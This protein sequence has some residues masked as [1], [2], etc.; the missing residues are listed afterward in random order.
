MIPS[1]QPNLPPTHSVSPDPQTPPETPGKTHLWLALLAFPTTSVLLFAIMWYVN[2]TTS[3]SYGSSLGC[4]WGTGIIFIMIAPIMFGIMVV[5]LGQSRIRSTNIGAVITIAAL[6]IIANIWFLDAVF[7]KAQQ[8]SYGYLLY[9]T[10]FGIPSLVA[11][12][13]VLIR[14]KTW[15]YAYIA[16]YAGLLIIG[17][18]AW[19]IVLLPQ[20][21]SASIQANKDKKSAEIQ[22]LEAEREKTIQLAKSSLEQAPS[23]VPVSSFPDSKNPQRPYPYTYSFNP[24]Q[25]SAPKQI[26]K[27]TL[28]QLYISEDTGD[29]DM[30]FLA[31]RGVS[32][33]EFCTSYIT[34]KKIV[35]SN[36]TCELSTEKAV[37]KTF[38]FAHVPESSLNFSDSTYIV[39][40]PESM[41][42]ITGHN[43]VS[44][45]ALGFIVRLL[46][47][48]D[49]HQIAKGVVDTISS[50]YAGK[51][52][53]VKRRYEFIP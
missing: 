8:S 11:I 1:Q 48:A 12:G 47:K 27:G 30:Q 37:D 10:C 14:S 29:F 3:C 52:Q 2:H 22:S 53:K 38:T 51:I 49:Q 20:I 36:S 43:D 15:L 28:K 31:K 41:L 44:S 6:S 21:R 4:G 26:Y 42:V 9:V 5:M 34:S 24:Y 50:D 23:Y 19:Y 13:A 45:L 35:R 18:A 17:V 40:L 25:D 16:V 39:E 46:V 7:A 33:T 32:L